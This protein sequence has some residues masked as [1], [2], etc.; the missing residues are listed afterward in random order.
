M[1]QVIA[2]QGIYLWGMSRKPGANVSLPPA[3]S[4]DSYNQGSLRSLS[5]NRRQ[6]FNPP[7]RVDRGTSTGLGMRVATES[8]APP[9]SPD[10]YNIGS[11]RNRT[12]NGPNAQKRTTYVGIG[13]PTNAKSSA[14]LTSAGESALQKMRA[15]GDTKA[16]PR[17]V[18]LKIKNLM[19]G[20]LE[21]D[22]EDLYS[23]YMGRIRL[24]ANIALTRQL[25][26]EEQRVVDD[27]NADLD[28]TS[29][30]AAEEDLVGVRNRAMEIRK[31]EAAAGAAAQEE[32]AARAILSDP[33]AMVLEIRERLRND[34]Y[35]RSEGKKLEDSAAALKIARDAAILKAEQLTNG[36]EALEN[37]R[38]AI[39]ARED[40]VNDEI[41]ELLVAKPADVNAQIALRK[42][43]IN[44]L[45]LE[46]K[47]IKGKIATDEKQLATIGNI[48]TDETIDRD[49]EQKF[50][51]ILTNE[52]E[53]VLPFYQNPYEQV[54]VEA[55]YAAAMSQLGSIPKVYS[56]KRFAARD[57]TNTQLQKL[58][59]QGVLAANPEL[60]KTPAERAAERIAASKESV[61]L[62]VAGQPDVEM[63]GPGPDPEDIEFAQLVADGT[64][65]DF[66]NLNITQPPR[67]IGKPP[68][69]FIGRDGLTTEWKKMY[70][71][72]VAPWIGR[73]GEP[74]KPI[75]VVVEATA[76]LNITDD[77]RVP[78]LS[79]KI[80]ISF[81]THILKKYKSRAPKR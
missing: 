16:D 58:Y 39:I 71:N 67:G 5:T 51:S 21:Q 66:Y 12:L 48:P 18:M 11:L 9:T 62:R 44:D 72:K 53:S 3:D 35:V 55:P 79:G 23:Q 31:A 70:P 63:K 4:P 46:E 10:S 65:K 49:V 14:K 33:D 78:E 8:M 1:T 77:P 27:I 47:A 28:A 6:V 38:E 59:A 60:R 50:N 42:Q 57:S 69:G 80:P 76:G 22:E 73:Y 36:L 29:A 43:V 37:K 64:A 20:N 15:P 7:P 68:P 56:N 45:R 26:P 61:M 32:T 25:T 24:L 81:R 30:M 52:A 54:L 13:P 19:E 41:A 17:I 2:P 40:E 74:N 75:K 34:P